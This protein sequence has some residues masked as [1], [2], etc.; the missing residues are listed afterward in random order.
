MLA[1]PRVFGAGRQVRVCIN[2]AQQWL[3]VR[4][5]RQATRREPDASVC[6]LQCVQT[7]QRPPALACAAPCAVQAHVQGPLRRAAASEAVAGTRPSPL[8]HSSLNSRRRILC[9][10]ARTQSEK[11]TVQSRTELP[12]REGQGGDGGDDE[13]EAPGG[14]LAVLAGGAAVLLVV[15]ASA[16]TVNGVEDT[17]SSAKQVLA[18]FSALVRDLGPTGY[19][20]YIAA[21]AGLELLFLPATPI[22]LSAGALF[23]VGPGVLISSV[24]GL[25][26][27]TSAFLI[28]RY[29]ARE[30][31]LKATAKMPKFKAIDRAIGR[32]GFKV[33]LLVNLSPLASLQNVLNYAYGA[34]PSI[35]IQSYMAA[36]YLAL[37]PR[38]WATVAAGSVGRSLMDGESQGAWTVAAGVVFAVAATV[39]VARIA[40]DALS[41]FEEEVD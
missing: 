23:G 13:D 19:L 3:R 39:Y 22:A 10:A 9:S 30:R 12:R 25:C 18:D 33:V 8:Q 17:L 31:V 14:E 5:C 36:S 21:Y 20:L 38:T 15:V 6:A 2:D 41:E 26:G 16:V 24:G 40:Q 11:E 35:R 32:D 29:V 28:G 37:L 1:T 4:R 34:M 27:A 7:L